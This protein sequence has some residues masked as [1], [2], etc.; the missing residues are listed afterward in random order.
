MLGKTPSSATRPTLGGIQAGTSTYGST[1][2]TVYG[3]IRQ[4]LLLIWL[5][6]LRKVGQSA[7]SKKKGSTPLYACNANFLLG[8][9]PISNVLQF[10]L[11]N[12]QLLDL[13]FQTHTAT[14]SGGSVTI[15]DA[16]FYGVIGVTVS[17]SYIVT[18]DDFGG[19]GSNVL[20]GTYD[21]PLWNTIVTGPDPTNPNSYRNWPYIYT[22]YPGNGASPTIFLD[23]GA[24]GFFN[25]KSVTIHYAAIDPAG[26]NFTRLNLHGSHVPRTALGLGFEANLGNGPEY[27]GFTSQQII[28]QCYAGL[29]APQLDLGASGVLPQI[30]C[31]TQGMSIYPAGDID[32][33]DM[34][35]DTF[36]S[37]ISQA[38]FD[39]PSGPLTSTTFIH[40]GLNCF[41]YPGAI[42][43]VYSEKAGA[44][45]TGKFNLPNAV[46][47]ML[48]AYVRYDGSATVPTI[49]DSAGNSWTLVSNTPPGGGSE[50]QGI[51]RAIAVASTT[52]T[53]TITGSGS[54]TQLVLLELS[55]V[56]TF[57]TATFASGSGGT[58]TGS[59]ITNGVAGRGELLIAILNTRTSGAVNFE[60]AIHWDIMTGTSAGFQSAMQRTVYSPGTYSITS[61]GTAVGTWTLTI[62]AFSLSVP[63]PFMQPLG[64]IIHQS[65]LEY[66]RTQA[67]AN[68]LFG[69][70]LLDSQR[71]AADWMTD[72]LDCGNVWALWSGF[73]LKF[74]PKSEVSFAG[75]GAVYVAL[76]SSANI[77]TLTENDFI[78]S[79]QSSPIDIDRSPQPDVPN[80]QQI[81][82]PL[83]TAGY[84]DSFATQPESSM[85]A[86]YGVVKASPRNIR[87]ITSGDVA[88][89]VLRVLVQGDNFG[90][91]TYKFT[92][93]AKWNLLEAGDVIQI[94]VAM[95]L[96]PSVANQTV[97]TVAM[98]LTSVQEDEKFQL[99][100][101]A[102]DY[103]YGQYAPNPVVVTNPNP[104]RAPVGHVP[105]LINPPV[106]LE[107]VAGLMPNQ[108][109]F[110]LWICI[111]CPDSNYG[112][113]Q[114]WMS[115]DG[116]N[117]YS[118]VGT[119]AGQ[120][121]TGVL[122]ADW[123][124]ATDPD[125]ANDL[126]LDLSESFGVLS[127][128]SVDN[129]NNFSFPA[130]VSGGG[131][132]LIPYEVMAW[133]N[134]EQTAAYQYTLHAA[135]SGNSLRRDVFS[136]PNPG[137]APDGFGV[138][139]DHPAHSAFNITGIVAGTNGWLKVTAT[140]HT[141]NSGDTAFIPSGVVGTGGLGA[142]LNGKYWQVTKF[143]ANHVLLN[144]T[145]F[146][147]EVFNEAHTVPGT[148]YQVT[149]TGAASF[150]AD[151]G[152]FYGS[153]GTRLVAV[154][155][156]PTQGQYA[157]NIATGVYTFA[158]ADAGQDVTINYT[159]TAVYTSGG[160][161]QPLSRFAFLDP[162]ES[163]IL[164][165]DMTQTQLN[166]TLH[167]KM[168]AFNSTGGGFQNIANVVDYVYTPI[169]LGDDTGLPA[170]FEFGPFATLSTNDGSVQM[171][172][173]WVGH[174]IPLPNSANV[175]TVSAE[176]FTLG[177]LDEGN[178]SSTLLTGNV[179]NTSDPVNI[180]VS[181]SSVFT[182][183]Q[184][185]I[186][187][188]DNELLS[189][190]SIPDPTHVIANRAIY[191]S[192]IIAHSS[193]A[194]AYPLTAFNYVYSYAPGDFENLVFD[195]GSA[196]SGPLHQLII[197]S[198]RVYWGAFSL[199]NVFGTTMSQPGV[200]FNSPD[201]LRT[202]FGETI[203]LSPVS[204]SNNVIQTGTDLL[205]SAISANA[206]LI[207][208]SI[209]ASV[210]NAPNG[211]SLDFTLYVNGAMYATVTIPNSATVSNVING[212]ILGTLGSI[213]AGATLTC[214]ITVNTGGATYNGDG[215]QFQVIF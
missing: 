82:Y 195:I 23:G 15:P 60:S 193:G 183:G 158:A 101:E 138:G 89:K 94:P 62:L 191:G 86:M 108:N 75:N 164:K 188:R 84:A 52:N 184:T 11:D 150:V 118:L 25:S 146:A 96:S 170:P 90:R 155:S 53:V 47:N 152:V 119:T 112:G 40:H 137:G 74:I 202:L 55:G 7:K 92:L 168:V 205:S 21:H 190:V 115:T 12:N 213:P 139:C 87:C 144:H 26:G 72:W 9:N 111:S 187:G 178:I 69:S 88:Q 77:P 204:P 209:R 8:S 100:C 50:G 167:F 36:K 64:N 143:D 136:A 37:G 22:W 57:D 171:Q 206:S 125:T 134:A 78:A 148:P 70:A 59:I 175:E 85:A 156:S 99:Q 66:A 120:A 182:V 91:N 43:K 2:P 102:Q 129:M 5:Q 98:R 162:Q 200:Y 18:V 42:Q 157:V 63:A 117:S 24:G 161:I 68:G 149:V 73:E 165:I 159:S 198:S 44:E 51:W 203:T 33:V 35:E 214:T 199:T 212:N 169:G 6:N 106:F 127:S 17:E 201:G 179:N 95:L 172:S 166:T 14:V 3:V 215:P 207:P 48:V 29:G 197:K 56:D 80:L 186:I 189:V 34:L 196:A 131:A 109:G 173:E 58:P 163:G 1:I 194:T 28:Y 13:L 135:G 20:S 122:T 141:F 81:Q 4:Q 113:S 107:P 79:G 31:E 181:D 153:D 30:L 103:N 110:F 126:A 208:Q 105:A 211:T 67:R 154:A 176:T 65:S 124:A 185:F 10:W 93:N 132:S 147:D 104:Y 27:D 174:N 38:G 19:P 192:T 54:H 39:P 145:T 123:P 71:K 45:T 140:G 114:V 16:N 97:D 76:Q 151:D 116:G 142:Y 133:F 83:R 128:Y 160:T 177:I 61:G 32:Y 130:F 46:G 41:D 210:K 180:A 49:S 121:V